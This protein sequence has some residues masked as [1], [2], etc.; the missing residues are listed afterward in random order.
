MDPV[1]PFTTDVSPGLDLVALEEVFPEFGK[2]FGAARVVDE[3]CQYPRAGCG[4]KVVATVR[5]TSFEKGM[6]KDT[7]ACQFPDA[8][9][10]RSS[11]LTFDLVIFDYLPLAQRELDALPLLAERLKSDKV[12]LLSH[13]LGDTVGRPLPFKAVAILIAWTTR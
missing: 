13:H 4:D 2:R 9:V 7:F 8:P 1:V 12:G 10:T 6:T 5:I 3:C 11:V